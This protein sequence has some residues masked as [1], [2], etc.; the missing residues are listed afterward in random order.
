LNDRISYVDLAAA[1]RVPEQR[2]KSMVR[3]A[4]TNTLFREQPDGNRVGHSATSALLA[5]DPDAYAYATY[6]CTKSAP[7][8]MH[9]A[10]AH[11]RWGADTMRT[12]ETA[13]N[14]AFETDLPFFDHLGRDKTRMSEF[15]AYMR[16]VRSSDALDLKHLV[17]GFAW[18]NIQDG[19]LVVDVSV[20]ILLLQHLTLIFH[21]FR[22][23]DLS[24][25]QP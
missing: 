2:I 12:Y 23:V 9:L 1:A 6:M 7:M 4:M 5:R 13:Y 16:H 25:V 3:M 21:P 15:A 10:A 19:G 11:R 14:A 20:A 8:A 24:A 17:S 18:Q 22:W